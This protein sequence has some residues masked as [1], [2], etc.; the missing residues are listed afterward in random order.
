MT[1]L[2]DRTETDEYALDSPRLRQFIEAVKTIRTSYDD[3]KAI[4]AAI[5]PH[6]EALLADQ[7]WLPTMYQEPH[8]EG[9]MGSGIGT[10]LLYRTTDGSLA[11]SSL[12]VP[13]GAQTPVHDHLAWGLVGLYRGEQDEEVFAR[14]DDGSSEDHAQ[15]EVIARNHLKPGDFYEL[16]PEVDIH[17]VKTTSDVT[18]VSLHL[19]GIDNGCI[20]RHRFLPEEERIV[21]FKSGYVNVACEQDETAPAS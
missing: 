17:R 16:L 20:W 5:R 15:L 4:I 18:S 9:G 8:P 1:D 3:P 6:F 10:W 14:N 7:A 2:L 11:L 19:L 13:P 12:V 21:P